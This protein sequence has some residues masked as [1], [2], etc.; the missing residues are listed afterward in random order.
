MRPKILCID[1]LDATGKKTASTAISK[2][3]ARRKKKV[4]IMDSPFYK[5]LSGQI[6]SKYLTDGYGSIGD[7]TLISA[8][9]SMDRNFYLQS[10]FDKIME[11]NFDYIIMNRWTITNL[12]FNTTMG[13]QTQDNAVSKVRPSYI[14]GIA[15]PP[16]ISTTYHFDASDGQYDFTLE[17]MHRMVHTSALP[18]FQFNTERDRNEVEGVI[19]FLYP[20]LRKYLVRD[21]A[22]YLYRTEI[23]PWVYEDATGWFHP[24]GHINHLF[25]TSS[26]PAVL[27]INLMRRYNGDVSKL[28]QNER[29]F[30]Y[31]LSVAENAEWIERNYDAIFNSVDL[32]ANHFYTT[33][34]LF[35]N[36]RR[37]PILSVIQ[38]N[39]IRNEVPAHIFRFKIM[40]VT[41]G[42]GEMHNINLVCR[43]IWNHFKLTEDVGEWKDMKNV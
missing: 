4:L 24:F 9:Y 33:A 16:S 8:Y 31:L 35:L 23:S 29:S 10:H 36:C 5:S 17:Q 18:E 21:H 30:I 19:Q 14:D 37:S 2:E 40:D 39:P 1:G 43:K 41:D 27:H 12:F 32:S 13:L 11:R 38:M 28:D 42:R 15:V 6:V 34:N 26:N 25:L 3:L 22:N 20:H 7:R